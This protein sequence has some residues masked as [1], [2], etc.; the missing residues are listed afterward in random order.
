[1]RYPLSILFVLLVIFFLGPLIS[2]FDGFSLS[3]HQK[4]QLPSLFSPFGKDSLGRDLFVRVCLGAQVSIFVGAFA[5]IVDGL[6]GVFLGSWLAL[7]GG[8]FLKIGNFALNIL[9]AIPYPIFVIVISTFT[10]QGLQS[11]LLSLA[12]AGWISLARKT[13]TL[14]LQVMQ[15]D[16]FLAAKLLGLSNVRLLMQHTLINILAP[17]SRALILSVP[18]AI[19]F[20]S[21]ISF[22]GI[23]LQ[24]PHPSL[25]SLIFEGASQLT[26]NPH[27]FIFPTLTLALLLFTIQDLEN[28][29]SVIWERKAY[30]NL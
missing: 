7:K 22:L 28:K 17:I 8:R 25:G 23:G 12:F 4:D 6:I 14:T 15:T 29:F 20:E 30:K 2:P 1:M 18:S 10:G 3:I 24:P 13:K 11:I 16:Y 19:F 5:F 21:F 9:H 26:L 27:L